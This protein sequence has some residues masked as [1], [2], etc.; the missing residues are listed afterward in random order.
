MNNGHE[1]SAS[2]RRSPPWWRL[3]GISGIAWFILFI[4]GGVALQGEPPAFDKPIGKVLAFFA[5]KGTQYLVGDYLL[6]IAFWFGFLPF[7]I[8]LAT[9]IDRTDSNAQIATRLVITGGLATV[10]VGGVAPIFSNALA[11]N[12]ITPGIPEPAA[13][14]LLYAHA[15]AIAQLG[16]P[17]SVLVFAAAWATWASGA[18]W[19]WLTIV[20]VID[21]I[22]LL[23]GA[24]FPIAGNSDGVLFLIRFISFIGLAI[25]VILTS[26]SMLLR[27][28]PPVRPEVRELA[29]A[30][31]HTGE[32]YAGR[33]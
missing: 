17:A 14:G 30:P 19:R 13:Q 16:L 2:L 10:I 26:L 24:A 11:L 7:V 23:I 9:L 25:W 8:C 18:V 20:A 12:A 1:M 28:S 33:L 31:A 15:V 27:S 21:G 6:K 29:A 5:D 22:L 4:I 3:G 32:P